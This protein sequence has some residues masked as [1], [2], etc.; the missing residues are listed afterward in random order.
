M[1]LSKINDKNLK[2]E[3]IAKIVYSNIGDNGLTSKYALVFGNSMLINERVNKAVEIYKQKRVEKLIFMGSANG[4]SNQEKSNIAEA[5]KMK[6]LA[7]ELGVNE[8]DILLDDTSNNTFENIDNALNIIGKEIKNIN[9]IVI[10]TSE[11]H[12]K[13]CYA[14]LKQKYPYLN[15]SLIPAKDGF[16]DSDNWFLSDSKWNSGRSLATYEAH[17]LIK[18]AKEN[19]IKDLDIELDEK[20]NEIY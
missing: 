18:Y 14:I 9:N 2:D 1:K 4:V 19:R 8:S 6:K 11:F 12:L 17:L 7:M 5:V 3:D 15:I 20:E 10:I 13:R 16:S